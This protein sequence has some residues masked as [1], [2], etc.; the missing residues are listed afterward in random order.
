MSNPQQLEEQ[1]LQA[2]KRLEL[3]TEKIIA[4]RGYAQ[5]AKKMRLLVELIKEQVQNENSLSATSAIR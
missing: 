2:L 4:T 5:D 3:A 1:L